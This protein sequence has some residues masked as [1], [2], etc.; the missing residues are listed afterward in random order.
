MGPVSVPIA[1]DTKAKKRVY[2]QERTVSFTAPPRLPEQNGPILP[3]FRFRNGAGA[4]KTVKFCSDSLYWNLRA[5]GAQ[6]RP[7]AQSDCD[8][9]MSHGCMSPGYPKDELDF[10]LAISRVFAACRRV[11]L[12]EV[13]VKIQ[14]EDLFIQMAAVKLIIEYSELVDLIENSASISG[15]FRDPW[16]RRQFVERCVE[17][18]VVYCPKL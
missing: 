18:Y 13:I 12:S 2:A 1:S 10:H 15:L 16:S 4:V 11:L 9:F 5:K 7:H 6:S 8:C 17:F 3:S 14:D